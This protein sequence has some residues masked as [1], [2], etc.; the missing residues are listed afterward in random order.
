MELAA[1]EMNRNEAISGLTLVH[2]ISLE[3]SS[4]L[5]PLVLRLMTVK[6]FSKPADFALVI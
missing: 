5:R 2:H 4:H 1:T 3:L 6:L